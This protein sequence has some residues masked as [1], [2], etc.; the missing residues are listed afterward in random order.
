MSEIEEAT[1]ERAER[2]C[3]KL[4]QHKRCTAQESNCQRCI[5]MNQ[6]LRR[7]FARSQEKNKLGVAKH[8]LFRLF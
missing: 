1:R 5:H 2:Q 6:T 7:D 8:A 3:H 4:E